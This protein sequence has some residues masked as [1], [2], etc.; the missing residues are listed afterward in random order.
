MFKFSENSKL[1]FK[2]LSQGTR[3]SLKSLESLLTM[4]LWSVLTPFYERVSGFHLL[5]SSL[6]GA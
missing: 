1:L 5:P 4:Y 2:D 3:K 6:T